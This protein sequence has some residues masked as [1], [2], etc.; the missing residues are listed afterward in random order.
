MP[1]HAAKMSTTEETPIDLGADRQILNMGPSHPAT[2]GTV[3]F[4]VEIEGETVVEMDV[5]VGYL[6]RG[7]EKECESGTYYQAIPYTD[8]LNYVSAIL[9]NLGYCMTVEKL[10]GIETPR[11][12]QWARVISGELS[13]VGDHLTRLGAGCLEVAAMTPFL[14]EIE[15]RELVWD[16]IEMLCGA[17][18]TCN[19]VRIGGLQR[20]VPEGFEDQ[21][22]QSMDRI[23]EL[24]VDFDKV[25]SANRIFVDRFRNTGILPKDRCVAY[26]VTGPLLRAAGVPYDVRKAEPYLV[27]DELDFDIPTGTIG[28]NFDRFLVVQEEIHQSIR[29]VRQCIPVLRKT[30]GEPYDVEDTRVRWPAKDHVFNRMEEL[31]QQFKVVTEGTKVPAGEAYFAIEAANGELGFYVVSDGTGKPYKVR[32]RPPSFINTAPLPEMIKGGLIADIIPTFDMINMIGGECD[33]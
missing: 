13:R 31:I 3:K 5:A 10:L 8:R 18:V 20:D 21:C 19:Y 12:C 33:R 28:D 7:F 11:R 32:C 16:L 26:G 23:D 6:H 24:M 1:E 25:I 30:R 29:I 2:H 9:G 22:E 17:R 14:Y 4:T 15:A 27:Y